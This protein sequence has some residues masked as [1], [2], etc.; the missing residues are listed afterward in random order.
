MTVWTL[1]TNLSGESNSIEMIQRNF[2]NQFIEELIEYFKRTTMADVG[3]MLKKLKFLCVLLSLLIC[4]SLIV[5]AQETENTQ[6]QD[7]PQPG[8]LYAISAVLVDGNTGRVLYE[9]NGYE[10]R[11]NAST[12]KIMTCILALENANLEDVVTAS[13]NAAAQPASSW[14]AKRSKIHT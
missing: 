7:V 8:Q 6:P 11:A 2:S 3:V 5:N 1:R 10:Q 4:S 13:D 9:K 12:T 14:D